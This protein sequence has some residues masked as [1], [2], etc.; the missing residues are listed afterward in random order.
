MF[1]TLSDV[2]GTKS[3][4]ALNRQQLGELLGRDERFREFEELGDDDWVRIESVTA[5]EM[6]AFL[7]FSV[8][9]LE[10]INNPLPFVHLYHK[11]ENAPAKLK[12][13]YAIS[14]AFIGFLNEV[15]ENP[16]L[17]R[18]D[19]IDPSPF[20]RMCLKKYGRL[21]LDISDD[22]LANYSIQLEIKSWHFP[23]ISEWTDITELNDLFHSEGLATQYGQFFDQRYIDYLH[24]NFDDIDR[25]NWRKF[26]GLTAEYFDRHGFRVDI[27]PG[28]NDEGVDVR[29]WPSNESPDSPPA[30]IVQCKRQKQS[31]EKVIVKSLY[32]DVLHA[33][34]TSGLIVT[35]SKLSPGAKAVCSARRYPIVEAARDTVRTWI[36]EMRK[37]GMGIAT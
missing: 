21:G 13:V 22:L 37:P 36:A 5:Q 2:V 24:R 20:M 35:T 6:I 32:A 31:I 17:K 9:R 16:D 1:G 23:S 18:G 7:L 34:A 29:V 11:Y 8:G 4:L 12:V 30:I 25:V 28:R 14:E 33:E 3:G 10:R 26:E 15:I 27:G 19:R